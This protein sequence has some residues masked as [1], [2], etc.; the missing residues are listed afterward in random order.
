AMSIVIYVY[1]RSWLPRLTSI[2]AAAIFA[3]FGQ[4]LQIGRLG[5]SEALFTLLV[6]SSMLTWH[7]GYMSGRRPTLTWCAAYALAAL[8]ALVK[9]P[10]APVYLITT[11]GCFLLVQRDWKWLVSLSHLAGMATFAVVASAWLVPFAL[12]HSGAVD[13]ILM[14][15]A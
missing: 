12:A 11:T 2:T 10:Q 5:E 7:A 3:T 4:V 13:D 1:C 8:A 15:L 6:G 9:G 14:G